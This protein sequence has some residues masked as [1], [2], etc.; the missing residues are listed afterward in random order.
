MLAHSSIESYAARNAPRPVRERT[1]AQAKCVEV[2][3]W[4]YGSLAHSGKAPLGH[5]IVY[6]YSS[7]LPNNFP[8]DALIK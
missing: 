2:V 6:D 4:R 7:L 8:V 3:G 5:C 1:L